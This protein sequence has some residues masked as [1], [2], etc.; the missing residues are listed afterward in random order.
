[1]HWLTDMR[2]PSPCVTLALGP[3]PSIP[4][5]HLRCLLASLACRIALVSIMPRL[6]NNF[7]LKA[8]AE[9][10]TKVN[11]EASAE[12]VYDDIDDEEEE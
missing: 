2:V 11:T 9:L 5:N 1:M 10:R 8:K 4:N 3:L 7:P 6:T 12:P